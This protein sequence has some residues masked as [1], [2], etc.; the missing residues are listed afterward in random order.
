MIKRMKSLMVDY[1]KNYDF[2]V[3][4]FQFGLDNKNRIKALEFSGLKQGDT[5]L[6][7]CCGTGLSFSAIQNIIGPKGRIIAVDKNER[8]IDLAKRRCDRHKWD[9]IKF[10]CCPIEDLDICESVDFVLLAYG[11][12]DKH[13][14]GFW[15]KRIK[16]M[17]ASQY[18]L[19]VI[20]YKLPNSR[21][22]RYL[23][24]PFLWFEIMLLRESYGLELLSWN[25][26]EEIRGLFGEYHYIAFFFDIII[27]MSGS[28]RD[29]QN[30]D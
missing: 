11:W 8:M 3:R 4:L 28:P 7:L 13:Q 19:C 6:D 10:V 17:L 30:N 23:V 5:V 20:D 21:W 18:R 12:Y 9:N 22:L 16:S 2:A 15:L 25:P 14:A 1:S 26:E 24:S 29:A 27:V